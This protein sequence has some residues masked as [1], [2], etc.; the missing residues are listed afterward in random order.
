MHSA[1]MG[2]ARFKHVKGDVV[3]HEGEVGV[4]RRSGE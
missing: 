4:G 1:I 2:T 3:S